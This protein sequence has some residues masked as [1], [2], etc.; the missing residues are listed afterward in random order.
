MFSSVLTKL[1]QNHA[2]TCFIHLFH[3]S[4][5]FYVNKFGSA[6]K[7]VSKWFSFDAMHCKSQSIFFYLT[8]ALT[9]SYDFIHSNASKQKIAT[10]ISFVLQLQGKLA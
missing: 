6:F 1:N 4:A 10:K 9:L 8:V 2:S 5:F 3:A 7:F